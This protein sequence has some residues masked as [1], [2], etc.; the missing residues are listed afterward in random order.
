[1]KRITALMD[2]GANITVS[3]TVGDLAEFAEELITKAKAE[4]CTSKAQTIQDTLLTACELCDTLGIKRPTLYK[5][6]RKG[7]IAPVRIGGRTY[8]RNS[9]VMGINRGC[10]MTH[11]A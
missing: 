1:M 5:W 9:D 11:A 3:I 10:N 6:Q 8:Y 7:Y 4:L 2:Y